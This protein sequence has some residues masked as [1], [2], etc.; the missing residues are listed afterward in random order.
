[1][2]QA[3]GGYL[4]SPCWLEILNLECG[5]A[6]FGWLEECGVRGRSI[7]P[8]RPTPFSPTGS[9]GSSRPRSVETGRP[10]DASTRSPCLDRPAAP[11]RGRHLRGARSQSPCALGV[12]S[13]ATAPRLRPACSRA[14]TASQSTGSKDSL[15]PSW[16]LRKTWASRTFPSFSS[17]Q[18]H[19]PHDPPWA[20]PGAGRRGSRGSERDRRRLG[21]GH[22]TCPRLLTPCT[23]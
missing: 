12:A 19:P 8:R 16:S 15:A 17:R 9:S 1:M 7:G 13:G 4:R 20:P 2:T 18:A 5:T 6:G 3:V 10:P 21:W 11:T 14:D 23:P 22:D